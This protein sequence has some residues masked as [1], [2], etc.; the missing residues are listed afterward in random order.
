MSNY[1][2]TA[3]S[4]YFKVKDIPG[5]KEWAQGH[6][7]EVFDGRGKDATFFAIGGTE[8]GWPSSAYNEKTGECEEIDFNAELQAHLADGQVA[9][10]MEGGAEAMRYVIG[11]A[12]AIMPGKPVLTLSLQDIYKIASEQFEV[13]AA[14]ISACEY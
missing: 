7:L 14:T 8:S 3:R 6:G 13:D 11:I 2:A 5:F 4:N 9:I 12:Q 1:Y 10:L